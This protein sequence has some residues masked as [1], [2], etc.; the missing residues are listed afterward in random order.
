M[1]SLAKSIENVEGM[2][3]S[4]QRRLDDKAPMPADIRIAYASKIEGLTC[5][6]DEVKKS[7]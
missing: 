2:I 3:V 1:Q 5:A 4:L 6:L 7:A